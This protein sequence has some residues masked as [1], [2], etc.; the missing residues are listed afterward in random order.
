MTSKA[1]L[2]STLILKSC[3]CFAKF[4]YYLKSLVLK[5]FICTVLSRNFVGHFAKEIFECQPDVT[6]SFVSFKHSSFCLF[7][8]YAVYMEIKLYNQTD[9]K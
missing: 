2:F 5:N 3:S 6:V 8:N 1:V 7:L 9:A 4:K